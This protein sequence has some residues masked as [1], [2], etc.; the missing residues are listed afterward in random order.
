MNSFS[1]FTIAPPNILIL[2]CK[3]RL[4]AKRKTKTS[5]EKWLLG[6]GLQKPLPEN[7][8]KFTEKYLCWSPLSEEAVFQRCSVK[9]K[10]LKISQNSKE[11]T[12]A[13]AWFL[14][15]LQA[16]SLKLYQ[17][18]DSSAGVS[19]KFCKISQMTFSYRTPLVAAS[20]SNTIK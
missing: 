15:K 19:C 16:L 12:S 9:R 4:S 3:P 5:C 20:A 14:I 17:K 7:F 11:N 18:R 10:F 13:R 8:T 6:S 2:R 1:Y